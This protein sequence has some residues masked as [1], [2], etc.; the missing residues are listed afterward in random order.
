[1]N[2]V[3]VF[4]HKDILPAKFS[5][6]KADCHKNIGNDMQNDGGD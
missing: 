1:M 4:A 2:S 6:K 5:L 3:F